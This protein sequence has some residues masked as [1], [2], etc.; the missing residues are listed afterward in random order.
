MSF[1]LEKAR[2]N[3]T[4]FLNQYKLAKAQLEEENAA[5]ELAGRQLKATAK[6]QEVFQQVAQ[7]VQQRAHDQIATV[8]TRCL[9]SIFEE[10]Y[11][12][13]KILFERKRGRTEARL[14][15]LRGNKEYTPTIAS[16][17]GV[18]D[19]A[20]MALRLSSVLL[21]RPLARRILVLDEPFK[22][23]SAGY[24]PKVAK[25]LETLA[26]ELDIQFILISHDPELKIG[27]VIEI[28]GD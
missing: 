4:K 9:A 8:V 27:K 5:L 14:I 18:I 3:I 17:G 24:R 21:T 6:A 25:M 15:F 13:F 16:G 2:K 23:L 12:S 7:Q 19:V 10:D 11:Y 20:A 1:N 28:G 26:E 22:M